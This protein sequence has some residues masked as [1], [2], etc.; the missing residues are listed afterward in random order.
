[1][2]STKEGHE[3]NVRHE[4]HEQSGVFR[5]RCFEER[6]EGSR[7]PDPIGAP[8]PGQLMVQLSRYVPPRIPKP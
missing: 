6:P 3:A 4:I 8:F 7:A 5:K 2:H 1:M